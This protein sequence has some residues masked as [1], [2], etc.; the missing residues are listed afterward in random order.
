MKI[1]SSDYIKK[2]LSEDHTVTDE[3]IDG[4][5]DGY[6]YLWVNI[7][8]YEGTNSWCHVGM[9]DQFICADTVRGRVTVQQR[10]EPD[11]SESFMGVDSTACSCCPRPC[12]LIF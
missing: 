11:T 3:T 1:V 7:A 4:A 8:Q 9:H 5:G 10:D 6:G 2:S 12:T